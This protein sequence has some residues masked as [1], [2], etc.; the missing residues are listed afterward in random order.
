M[1]SEY[2]KISVDFIDE[3]PFS[4]RFCS[5]NPV[6]NFELPVDRCFNDANVLNYLQTSLQRF[7][8]SN[9]HKSE[10]LCY[11]CEDRVY[12]FRGMNVH[13]IVHH[14]KA[15]RSDYIQKLA[16]P[17][18]QKLYL[19]SKNSGVFN[20]PV[21][22]IALNIPS[23]YEKVRRPM[24][25]G[26][27]RNYLHCG[28]YETIEKC[29]DDVRL[30]FQNAVTFNGKDHFIAKV[31]LE[32]LEEFDNEAKLL[33]ERC[34]KDAS[35]KVSHSCSSCTG[36][37]CLLCG[38]K[39]L[40]FE[41]P[42]LFCHGT[43]CAQKI[44]KGSIYFITPCGSMIWCQKCYTTLPPVLSE[45]IDQTEGAA[46]LKKALLKRK[47]EQEIP[48]AWVECRRCN[49][50]FHQICA[51]YC[52]SLEQGEN[53]SFVCP[54]C[55][56]EEN[57]KTPETS[58]VP[59]VEWIENEGLHEMEVV[60]ST[61][62]MSLEKA[63]FCWRATS[64]PQSKLADFLENLVKDL[65]QKQGFGDIKETITIR[66]TSNLDKS[67]EVPKQIID[68]VRGLNSSVLPD[69]IGYKQKCIQL[70][71]NID[72]IDVSLFCLYVHEFDSSCPHPNQSSVYIAYLDSV[73]YFRP[74][75]ARSMVYQEIIVGYLIWAQARGFKRC[76]I[77]SCP[78]QRGDSF[79]FWIHP[80]HQRTPS[81]DRLNAWYNSILSRSKL[82]GVHSGAN[83]LWE[84]YFKKFN[85]REDAPVREAAKRSFVGSGKAGSKKFRKI[86]SESRESIENEIPESIETP[87]SINNPFSCPP[88]FDGDYWVLEYLKLFR[89]QSQK[90]KA[91][92]EQSTFSNHRK[93]R[94]IL[95]SLVSRPH[96]VAFRQPVDPVLLCIP[97][98][99][100]IISN[101]MDLGTIRDK[102]R[103]NCYGTVWDFVQVRLKILFLTWS[104]LTDVF[105]LG[106]SIDFRQ[107]HAL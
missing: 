93:C 44:K 104:L 100:K 25:L 30:V 45:F 94:D 82:L 46:L 106:H 87:M 53:K 91:F 97:T 71:Q 9:N 55:V 85:H 21:D 95:K 28:K 74:M 96:S 27:V 57:L 84:Q 99:P 61:E 24:D 18:I 12:P 59:E 51:L 41:T 83:H 2:R 54:F 34:A 67:L 33:F 69:M 65:L 79:I 103:S 36:A 81:R 20:K 31:A 56:L 42:I 89:I 4:P 14:T 72:G 73:D 5:D 37:T 78:P 38:D 29:F 15:L 48:E 52:N 68:N 98:Y 60:S 10:S 8:T 80:G 3:V 102:L 7:A 40:K 23:Y 50:Q 49:L 88:I 43:N 6:P 75:Q 77:W 107:C 19:H 101:P 105:L 64:L 90:S 62:K 17:V 11:S 16:R 76:H 66:M 32:L 26:T 92:S 22:P 13:D 47:F 58:G 63:N 86:D 39:C 35:K 70:F 1:Y